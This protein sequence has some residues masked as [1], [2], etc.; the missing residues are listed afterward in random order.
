MAD[1]YDPA[2]VV[3]LAKKS[4]IKYCHDLTPKDLDEAFFKDSTELSAFE[5]VHL[6]YCGL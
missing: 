3:E 4:G 1:G 5:G 6:I 2:Q